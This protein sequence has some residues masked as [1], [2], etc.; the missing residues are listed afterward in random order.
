[1]NYSLSRISPADRRGQAELD[2]L[3]EGEGIRRD[4]NLDYTVGLFDMDHRLVATGSTFA[5]SLRCLAVD[6]GYQGEGLMAQVVSHIVSY[7]MARG[8]SHLFIYTK[9]NNTHIFNDLGFYEIARVDG[10]V[11]FMENRRTGFRDFLT[12]L[13]AERRPG[14]SAAVVMNCNP[15]TLGHLHLVEHAAAQNDWVH[16]F[17]VS[18]DMSLIP[19]SHRFE[20]IK[21]G[22]AH[23]SNVI[24]H[25][26]GSYMISSAVFPS[27]F[28][29]DDEAAIEVQ[30]RLDVM[31]FGSIAD[32]LGVSRR[33]V[34]EEPF[35]KVTGLYNR[36]MAAELPAM[37]IE[38][39]EI[40]RREQNGLAISASHV[41]RLLKESGVEA[42]KPLV[43]TTTYS[44]FLT[45]EGAAVLETIRGAD[46]VI[47]Y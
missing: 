25:K 7:Q 1:M 4:P 38:L 28:L 40:P 22:C 8:N 32:S 35:S 33:Y 20:L 45:D 14:I 12:E 6:S 34:G 17:A 3:L 18:E 21:A 47:H 2:R 24:F 43:P 46:N 29:E 36:V 11:S 5:N 15:F 13:A 26:T 41:R 16:L 42:V 27:Y 31:L 37:G 9:C 10:Q 19:F 44:F 23:L 39:I 30:A